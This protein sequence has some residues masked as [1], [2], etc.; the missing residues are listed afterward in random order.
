MFFKQ[1]DLIARQFYNLYSCGI[2]NSA[3]WKYLTYGLNISRVYFPKVSYQNPF[4]PEYTRASIRYN[5]LIVT[6]LIG[7]T[8]YATKSKVNSYYQQN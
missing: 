1:Y 4:E 3:G 7:F 2:K 6:G 5:Y 8:L